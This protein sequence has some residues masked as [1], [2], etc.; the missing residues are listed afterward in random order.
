MDEPPVE[1][2][3]AK[4]DAALPT[5][6]GELDVEPEVEAPAASPDGLALEAEAPAPP[7][8]VLLSLIHI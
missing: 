6:V 8:L 5:P 2:E 7:A 3:A 4:P 1:P